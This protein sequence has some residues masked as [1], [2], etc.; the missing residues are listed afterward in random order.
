MLPRS[1]AIALRPTF[2]QQCHYRL[3]TSRLTSSPGLHASRRVFASLS[4]LSQRHES[5]KGQAK[6]L[7]NTSPTT[8]RNKSIEQSKPLESNQPGLFSEHTVSSKEQRK[9]DWVIVKDMAHYLWP[10]NDLGTRFRVGL[11]VA[12]LVGAKVRPPVIFPKNMC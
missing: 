11:S 4:R 9:A 3:H 8:D 2:H 10:K 5:P 7:Q 1:V 6:V 12:L